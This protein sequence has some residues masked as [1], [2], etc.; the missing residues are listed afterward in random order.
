MEQNIMPG[1]E[2][3]RFEGNETGIL[4]SHGFTGTT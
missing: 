4:V 2:P 3:F 1:A